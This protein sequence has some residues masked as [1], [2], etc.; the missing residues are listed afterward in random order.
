[1]KDVKVG[2]RIKVTTDMPD[3]QPIRLGDELTVTG[4]NDDG[5]RCAVLAYDKSNVL[6]FLIEAWFDVVREGDREM[7]RFTVGQEITPKETGGIFTYGKFYRVRY[8]LSKIV[9]AD[10]ENGGFCCIGDHDALTREEY[11]QAEREKDPFAPG[12]WVVC[13]KDDSPAKVGD[14]LLI[15]DYSG[16]YYLFRSESILDKV[17]MPHMDH[18]PYRKSHFRPATPEEIK[19]QEMKIM[20]EKKADEARANRQTFTVGGKEFYVGQTVWSTEDGGILSE[21]D[22]LEVLGAHPEADTLIIVRKPGTWHVSFGDVKYLTTTTKP[23]PHEWKF[24]DWA[25]HPEWGVVLVGSEVDDDG[26]V[27]I[28]TKDGFYSHLNPNVSPKILTYISTAEIP[29]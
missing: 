3:G 4:V 9:F 2:D 29:E 1:M 24:G 5:R 20:D 19:E 27:V 12:K 25:R 10:G 17:N 8:A 16:V 23:K 26:D 28:Y 7:S 6:F 13:V 15:S 14:V 18:F 11:E 21:G 22:E